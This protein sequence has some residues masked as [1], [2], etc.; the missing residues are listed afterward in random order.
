[1]YVCMYVCVCMLEFI[2]TEA[3][4]HDMSNISRASGSEVIHSNNMYQHYATANVFLIYKASYHH[5]HTHD[6]SSMH[7]DARRQT[8]STAYVHTRAIT[9]KALNA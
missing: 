2:A 9:P 6:Q 3:H 1:M 8:V 7:A 4:A 5:M